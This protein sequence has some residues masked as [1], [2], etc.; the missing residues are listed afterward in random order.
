MINITIINFVKK[1][2]QYIFFNYKKN[3]NFLNI[4]TFFKF[5]FVFNNKII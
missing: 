5:F 3:N 1:L 2:I 4:L